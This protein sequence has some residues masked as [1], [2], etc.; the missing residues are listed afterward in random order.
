MQEVA[1]ELQGIRR[2]QE[3]AIE[4]QRQSFQAEL[5]RLEIT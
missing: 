2:V 1:R 5:E 3:K 4:A